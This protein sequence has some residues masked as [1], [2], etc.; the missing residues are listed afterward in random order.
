MA[1]AERTYHMKVYRKWV[2]NHFSIKFISGLLLMRLRILET[3]S[4]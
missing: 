1:G 3:L 2:C 4:E